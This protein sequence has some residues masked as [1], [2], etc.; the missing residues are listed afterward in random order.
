[1]EWIDL[2]D[3]RGQRLRVEVP[4]TRRERARGLR[5][6]R[7]LP[8]D[9]ALLLRRCRSVHTFGM[10]FSI[11]AVLLDRC[12]RVIDVVAMPPGRLLLPR[13]V[14]RHILECAQGVDL[15][16]GD[17]LITHVVSGGARS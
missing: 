5:G 6:R 4:T 9:Q 10:G 17:R 11:D 15:R 16:P 8:P 14:V 7:D 1:M 12:H 2:V 3:P 13:R